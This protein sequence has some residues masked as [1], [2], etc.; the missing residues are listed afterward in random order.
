M[1]AAPRRN[2]PYCGVDTVQNPSTHTF[3]GSQQSA[4]V[5]HFSCGC[6]HWLFGGVLLHTSPPSPALGSQYPLQHWS[7]LWQL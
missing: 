7:P 3:V 5:V 6:E 4:A 1:L 2:A